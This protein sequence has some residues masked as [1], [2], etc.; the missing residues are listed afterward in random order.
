[1]DEY[2]TPERQEWIRETHPELVFA[3]LAGCPMLHSKKKAEGRE[4]RRLCLQQHVTIPIVKPSGCNWDDVL[5]AIAL[6]IAARDHSRAEGA[7][8]PAGQIQRDQRG[9]RMEICF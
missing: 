4:E 5:D 6:A 3:R 2:L 9:L 1:V 8:L 7:S